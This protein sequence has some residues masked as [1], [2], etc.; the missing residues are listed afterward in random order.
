M[1]ARRHSS[2]VEI[3]E[4]GGNSTPVDDMALSCDAPIGNGAHAGSTGGAGTGEKTTNPFHADFSLDAFSTSTQYIVITSVLF[5][6]TLLYGYLQELVSGPE[7][8]SPHKSAF[9]CS[10][11]SSY[12]HPPVALA[13]SS[14][15]PQP[16]H[17]FAEQVCIHLFARQYGLFLTL[18]QFLGYTFF[19]T[20]QRLHKG[21]RRR[22]TI[23]LSYCAGLAVSQA[24]MQGLSNVAMRYINYPAKV[25]FKS[26]RVLPT[27]LVGVVVYRKRYS[28]REWLAVLLL[29]AGLVSFMQADMNASPEMNPI[30]IVLITL[31]LAVDSGII[32]VQDH[33][34]THFHSDEDEVTRGC[35]AGRSGGRAPPPVC[36]CLVVLLGKRRSV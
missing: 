8:R 11:L 13:R 3:L 5:F 22:H 15:F 9:P 27:M 33:C 18:V 14:P 4:G 29:V 32:N 34:F 36:C 31:S 23:P 28:V 10:V 6:F 25:L 12:H 26:C 17:L 16:P 30:G 35:F 21:D 7:L 2:R 20:L 1:Y 24:S 19:A